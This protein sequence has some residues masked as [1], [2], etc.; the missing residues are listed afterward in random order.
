MRDQNDNS[1]KNNKRLCYN[2]ENDARHLQVVNSSINIQMEA[3]NMADRICYKCARYKDCQI[4]QLLELQ[5]LEK[6]KCKLFK[7]KEAEI[8]A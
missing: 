4:R 2:M 8:N 1:N 3:V 6:K 5:G 7:A